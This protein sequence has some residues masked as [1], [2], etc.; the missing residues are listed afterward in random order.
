MLGLQCVIAQCLGL[1][2]FSRVLWTST[3]YRFGRYSPVSR[4]LLIFTHSVCQNALVNH[5]IALCLGLFSFSLYPF[6]K[7]YFIRLPEAKNAGY[8][9]SISHLRSSISHFLNIPHMVVL[10]YHFNIF[11]ALTQQ[12]SNVFRISSRKMFSL[13]SIICFPHISPVICIISPSSV[14]FRPLPYL[15]HQTLYCL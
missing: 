1:F 12:E 7:P 11:F 5:V 10:Y 2:S 15:Y 9:S 13:F 3:Y 14:L 6:M 4:A 8:C